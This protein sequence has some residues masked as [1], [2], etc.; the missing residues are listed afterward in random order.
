MVDNVKY[1]FCR[2]VE[3]KLLLFK[4][5]YEKAK[6]QLMNVKRERLLVFSLT[7]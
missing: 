1:F 5:A 4:L 2:V 3:M 7:H 6:L